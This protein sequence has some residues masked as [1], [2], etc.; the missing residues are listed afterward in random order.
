MLESVRYWLGLQLARWH[1]RTSRDEMLTFTNAVSSARRVLLVMPLADVEALPAMRVVEM[2]KSQ[3]KEENI[4]VV[5]GD[6]GVEVVRMLPRS[7]FVHL[8]KPQVNAVYL[9]HPG[10][11]NSLTE[12]HYDLAI[13][14]NLDL[15]LPSGY[16][17]K[18]SGARI[19]I[20]F[21]NRQADIF[22]NFQIKADPT[23]GRKETYDRFV[24]CLQQF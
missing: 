6:R 7:R 8:L 2:L 3:F 24:Q 21:N 18:A 1:Y 10:F 23:L 22:Y 15:V 12:R 9:P 11:I 4:T 19:R 20:G 13:D 5:M 17:C 14:L 16:I